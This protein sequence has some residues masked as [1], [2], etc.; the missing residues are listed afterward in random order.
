MQVY[1]QSK[2]ISLVAIP[3]T[4]NEGTFDSTIFYLLFLNLLSC[5]ERHFDYFHSG[6]YEQIKISLEHFEFDHVKLKLNLNS[7]DF[8]PIVELTFALLV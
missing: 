2:L 6:C 4:K 5:I 1:F 8:R 3:E 7:L